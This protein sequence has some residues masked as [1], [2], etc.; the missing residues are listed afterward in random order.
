MK[1]YD[2]LTD[3]ILQFM[4]FKMEFM[5]G[6]RMFVDALS[7][8]TNA[9]VLAV[10]LGNGPQC[11]VIFDEQVIKSLQATDPVINNHLLFHSNIL[12]VLPAENQQKSSDAYVQ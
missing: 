12:K 11:P 2:T 4:P 3:E 7:R 10:N 8:P 9:N 1:S 5:N 6:N